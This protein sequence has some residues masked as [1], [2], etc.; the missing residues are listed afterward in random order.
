MV[1]EIWLMI[2]KPGFEDGLDNENGAKDKSNDDSSPKEVNTAG[3]HV[4]TTSPD[5]NTGSFKLNTIGP[6]VNTASSY[7]QDSPKDMFTMGA[8]HTLKHV[9][10]EFFI[11]HKDHAIENVI[12]DVKLSVQI[13]RMTKPTSKQGFLST[14][15]PTSIAKA[16]SDSSW[17]EAMQEELLQFKLQQNKARLV[18]QGHRQE[19]GIDYEEVFAPV[20]RI[21]AIRLFLAYTS[22]MSFLVYQ[23]DVKS[24]FL[25]GFIEEEVYITQP[26]G[27]K[28][29]DHPD[30]V[31]K[32]VKALYELYQAPRA[33]YETLAN[34]LLGNGFK[35]G[36]VDQTLFIK[37]QKGDILLVISFYVEFLWENYFL[38]RIYKYREGKNGDIYRQYIYV[39]ETFK[40]IQLPDVYKKQTVV[41]TSTTKAE[42][43]AAASCYGQIFLQKVLMQEE[44]KTSRHVKRGRDTKIPQSSGSLKKVG[45]E[46]V[47]KELGDRMERAATTASSLEARD[48]DAQTRFEAAFKSPMIHHS[49]EEGVMDITATIYRKVKLLVTEAS[50]RRHLNLEDSEGL[51][52]LPTAEIFEQLA[53]MGLSLNELTVLCTS[54]SK[55]VKSL[56]S[57][58]HQ[59]KQTYSTAF[60]KLIKR[61]KKLEHTIKTSRARR[62]FKVVLSDNEE[63]ARD[64]S[65]QGNKIFDIDKDPTISLVQEEGMAWSQEDLE[66]QEKI[67]DDTE[68]VLEEEEPTELVKDQV[69]IKRSAEKRKDK[70]K[71]IMTEPEPE[72]T[73]TKLKLIQERAGLEAAIRLQEQLNEEESQRIARDAEI[74]RQLQEEI[75]IAGQEKVVTEDDQSHDIN[76]NDPSNQDGYK[77]SYFKGMSYEDIRPIFERTGERSVSVE[78]SKVKELVEPS[79]E[80]IQEMKIILPE[81]GM[82]VEALQSKYPIIDWEVHSEDT[83]KFW[84]IIRVG[85][86]TELYQTFADMLKNF[87]RYDLV[88][89][90]E[91]IK[92]G[93]GYVYVVEKDYPYK[94]LYNCSMPVNKLLVDTWFRMANEL[95]R[96]ISFKQT[97]HGSEVFERNPRQK[98]LEI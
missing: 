43:V 11:I 29:P 55:K 60:T 26:P 97:S 74:A 47:H 40:K 76:W 10:V 70:G 49:Q 82:H 54:L 34:Y 61:V 68:V 80:E 13:R 85:N 84:K 44:S 57:E 56:E 62:S 41:A 77:M 12:G 51:N 4:N 98:R 16:L 18:A 32:V 64:P 88:K 90:W 39:A 1:T 53:L 66:I 95:L 58:L 91:L 22:F 87:D 35:R 59:T 33:W 73:T 67:S 72:Q 36:K 21:E 27:F 19:E 92:K 63:E 78:E 31:Y 30:K 50:L 46:A 25:Y 3:Q 5:V 9:S 38:S 45:D 17:V 8:S 83:M 81:E 52:T 48:S 69:Y 96:K 42:Y 23:M 94:R 14:I 6:S 15:E 37:K 93:F 7:N 65:K 24:A 71:A 79:Q 86:Y 28:D 89:L 75:N 2:K 20:A